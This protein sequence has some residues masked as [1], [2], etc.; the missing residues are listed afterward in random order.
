MFRKACFGTLV[1]AFAMG[2]SILESNADTSE[3]FGKTLICTRSLNGFPLTLTIYVTKERAFLY[4]SGK[5]APSAAG[6]VYEFGRSRSGMMAGVNP[7]NSTARLSPA[8]IELSVT[9]ENRTCTICDGKIIVVSDTVR[10][11]GKANEW[12]AVR[13]FQ[14]SFPDGTAAAVPSGSEEYSCS[15]RNGRVGVGQ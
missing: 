2:A 4:H 3:L 1:I 10:I 14:Q 12:T 5:S 8:S 11:S 13:D 9:V 15:K 6:V 7:Y